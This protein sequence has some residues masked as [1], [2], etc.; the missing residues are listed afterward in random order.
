MLPEFTPIN[1][2]AAIYFDFNPPIITNLVKTTYISDL[3]LIT[4]TNEIEQSAIQV[5]P[6]PS[7]GQIFIDSEEQI[8][9]ITVMD[10]TG[11]SIPYRQLNGHSLI[12][13]EANGMYLIKIRTNQ[14]SI[15]KKVLIQAR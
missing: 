4:S 13:I 10:I 6:N 15:M 8:Q 12:E 2:Q 14:S 9:K 5:F 3:S 1:N 7:M 11:A